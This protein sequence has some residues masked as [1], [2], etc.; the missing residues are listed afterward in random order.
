MSQKQEWKRVTNLAAEADE[1]N[2]VDDA[3]LF[4]VEHMP[5]QI[6][7]KAVPSN[8]RCQNIYKYIRNN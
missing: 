3:K 5:E 1:R 8:F 2:K 4:F 7:A 6:L